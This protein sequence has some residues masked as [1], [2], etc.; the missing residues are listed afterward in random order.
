MT[1]TAY[2]GM[3]RPVVVMRVLA[4]GGSITL[5]GFRSGGE[6]RFTMRVN[7]AVLLDLL[8]EPTVPSRLETARSWVEALSLID[9]YSWHRLH[10]GEVHPEFRERV[11]EAVTARLR[12][13]G[14]S[15]SEALDRWRR[16]CG[17]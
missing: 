4:E 11:L 10:P 2:G 8:D 6:W 9:R 7:E 15:S 5:A 14:G 1:N 13:D 12:L 17:G 16:F 3:E